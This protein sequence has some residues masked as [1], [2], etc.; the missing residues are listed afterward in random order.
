MGRLLIISEYNNKYKFKKIR[1]N[2]PVNSL[3]FDYLID[4]AK[5]REYQ[6]FGMEESVNQKNSLDLVSSNK[7]VINNYHLITKGFINRVV[8]WNGMKYCQSQISSF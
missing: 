5:P 7:I 3:F 4:I 6:K 8:Y 2:H 1:W